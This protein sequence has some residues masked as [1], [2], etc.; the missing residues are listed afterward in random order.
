MSKSKLGNRIF[1]NRNHFMEIFFFFDIEF[2]ND[3]LAIEIGF[4]NRNRFLEI[5]LF[6]DI[7]V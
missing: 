3:F 1:G 2:E 4:G 7:D 6:W 5:E